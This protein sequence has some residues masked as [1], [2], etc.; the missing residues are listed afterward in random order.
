RPADAACGSF[1]SS[2]SG[3]LF[4]QSRIPTGSQP[5]WN[6]KFRSESVNY[7]Q[8]KEK[9]NVQPGLLHGDVLVGIDL[10]GRGDVKKR[11]DFAFADHVVIICAA[12]SRARR[13]SGRIL[14]ELADLLL[15]GHL[16]QE[17][18]KF[19]LGAWIAQTRAN[20]S[21]LRHHGGGFGLRQERL[22]ADQNGDG[23][24]K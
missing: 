16:L 14:D 17:R 11:P 21:V 7:V 20:R 4:N 24:H 8:A 9:W 12:G 1:T 15:K 3:C 13:L 23:G 5:Q 18:F 19:F 10:A 6:R 2:N 22:T